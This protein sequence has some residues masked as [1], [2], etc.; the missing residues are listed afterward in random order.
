MDVT[1]AKAF[2]AIA[3]SRTPEEIKA[4]SAQML[5]DHDAIV[6]YDFLRDNIEKMEKPVRQA[7]YK[8]LE[9]ELAKYPGM[10]RHEDPVFGKAFL[11]LRAKIGL[12]RG[13]KWDRNGALRLPDVVR[14][15]N[16][17]AARAKLDE[18]LGPDADLSLTYGPKI[19]AI[20]QNIKDH[21]DVLDGKVKTN[22]SIWDFIVSDAQ[23]A[24]E[25]A[26]VK[27]G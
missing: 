12:F 7:L 22:G 8:R 16:I 17:R 13:V 21:Q 19:E 23:S 2:A 20:K 3:K 6:R 18:L 14:Q 1:E 5:A 4:F 27:E 11:G 24:A 26:P 25:L 15:E 9:A 10:V